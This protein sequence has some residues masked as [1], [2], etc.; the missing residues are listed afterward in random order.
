MGF[1]NKP[2]IL[3]FGLKNKLVPV[4]TMKAQVEQR[5]SCMDFLA[6]LGLQE[7]EWPVSGRS[8]STLGTRSSG[9]F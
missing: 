3:N 2:G 4:N 9:R 8:C 7:G 5:H 6:W 1:V